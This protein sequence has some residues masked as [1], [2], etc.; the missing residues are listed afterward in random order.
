MRTHVLNWFGNKPPFYVL[1]NLRIQ[2]VCACSQILN[3]ALRLQCDCKHVWGCKTDPVL[4]IGLLYI[5]VAHVWLQ[6]EWLLS[7]C[8]WWTWHV[9]RKLCCSGWLVFG[10]VITW[11]ILPVVICLSQ[12]LSHACLRICSFQQ[13]C[14][15]LIKTVTVLL[16]VTEYM[17]TCGNSTANTWLG[18]QLVGR[19]MFISSRTSPGVA[20]WRMIHN[21]WNEA[22]WRVLDFL[23]FWPISCWW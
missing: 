6:R 20:R 22:F 2:D 15:W 23:S 18:S 21:N 12:R 10:F 17:D 3:V 8:L 19:D 9:K 4:P 1:K 13:I 5:S 16:A 11:L 14:K 7:R